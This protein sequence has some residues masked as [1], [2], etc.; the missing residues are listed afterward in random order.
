[1]ITNARTCEAI[2]SL[3]P[4]AEFTVRDGVVEWHD[5]VQLE[6]TETE[7]SAAILAIE[8]AELASAYQRD[9]A[10]E[11][12]PI[13]DQLDVLWKQLSS[14][15]TSGRL[16]LLQEADAMLDDILSTKMKYTK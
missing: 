11:Y 5:K 8:D 2:H 12:P 9:R 14:L 7:I 3:R 1:M 16:G 10:A 15:R 4:R 13:G 6:P